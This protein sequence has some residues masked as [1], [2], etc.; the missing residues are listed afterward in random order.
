MS[1]EESLFWTVNRMCFGNDIKKVKLQCFPFSK[2]A[3]SQPVSL[4]EVAI[5]PTYSFEGK[6]PNE[7]RES[8]RAARFVNSLPVLPAC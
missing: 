4:G 3:H 6:N 5:P 2:Q 8:N 7:V 1:K